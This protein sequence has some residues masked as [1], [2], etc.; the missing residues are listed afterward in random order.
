[1]PNMSRVRAGCG[2][3]K[4]RH[5]AIYDFVAGYAIFV[6]APVSGHG[7]TGTC[8]PPSLHFPGFL[9]EVGPAIALGSA[10]C[11]KYVDGV[12]RLREQ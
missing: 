4:N 11:A 8:H 5:K 1:M 6:R 12:G 7:K 10:G 2:N 3:Y 9:S